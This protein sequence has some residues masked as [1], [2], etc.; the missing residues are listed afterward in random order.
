MPASG[1]DVP[2]D[3]L[4]PMLNPVHQKDLAH[5][6]WITPEHRRVDVALAFMGLTHRRWAEEAGVTDYNSLLRWLRK[7]HRLPLGAAFRLARVI[8]V[9]V[10]L[11]FADYF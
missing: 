1:V 7:E 8:G 3:D 9:E 2:V 10:D 11:L 4:Q 6:L 5:I